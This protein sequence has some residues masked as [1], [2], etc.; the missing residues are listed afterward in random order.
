MRKPLLSALLFVSTTTAFAQKELNGNINIP[1][2]QSVTVEQLDERAVD[3]STIQDYADGK[4]VTAYCHITVK[5]NFPWK[6][7]GKINSTGILGESSTSADGL[8]SIQKQGSN[9]FIPLSV[10]PTVI[11][12]SS[13]NNIVN[14]YTFNLKVDPKL[15]ITKEVLMMNLAFALAP[16]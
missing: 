14:E 3:F 6:L 13:N 11:L 2:L 10:N 9:T 7:V 4:V 5:S 8:I 12:N 1:R 16:L 15:K